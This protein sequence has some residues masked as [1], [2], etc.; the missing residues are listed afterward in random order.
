[1]YTSENV[2]KYVIKVMSI[3]GVDEEKEKAQNLGGRDHLHKHK[4]RY[5]SNTYNTILK[6]AI[7]KVS[8]HPGVVL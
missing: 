1:M 2:T 4:Y 6:V 3:K 8:T 5:Q 7:P